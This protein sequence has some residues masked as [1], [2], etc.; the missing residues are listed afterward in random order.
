MR[1]DTLIRGGIIVDGSGQ[2]PFAA[3]LAIK[4]GRIAAIGRIEGEAD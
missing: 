2:E 4:D 3:D 1:F